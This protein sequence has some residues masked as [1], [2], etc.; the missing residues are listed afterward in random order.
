MMYIHI[1]Y[2]V[3]IY[4]YVYLYMYT[5]C[6]YLCICI[7]IYTHI[8]CVCVYLYMLSV[9]IK[10]CIMYTYRHRCRDFRAPVSR[11]L[12]VWH[13]TTFRQG[14]SRLPHECGVPALEVNR[15][16]LQKSRRLRKMNRLDVRPGDLSFVL[17]GSEHWSLFVLQWGTWQTKRR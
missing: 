13:R 15:N 3:Y 16:R 1:M 9:F 10:Q 4:I 5:K 14:E 8:K 2:Y 11:A 12:Q 17:H 7:Y 6:V